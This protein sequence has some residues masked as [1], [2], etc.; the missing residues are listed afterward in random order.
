M[1]PDAVVAVPAVDAVAPVTPAE[2]VAP[3]PEPQPA[4][5]PTVVP[6][7][8]GPPV[9]PQ[10]PV[11]HAVDQ[12]VPDD[13]EFGPEPL[14][15]EPVRRRDPSVPM[16]A[17]PALPVMAPPKSGP[18][19]PPEAVA[20]VAQ[21]A[22]PPA[23][24]VPAQAMVWIRQPDPD[25][26]VPPM[27][28]QS[29]G[30]VCASDTPAVPPAVAAMIL[31]P[32]TLPPKAPTVAMSPVA[33]V[34]KA[35]PVPAVAEASPPPGSLVFTDDLFGP[36]GVPLPVQSTTE[37]CILCGAPPSGSSGPAAP[38]GSGSGS[39]LD[40]EHQFTRQSIAKAVAAVGALGSEDDL[41]FYVESLRELHEYLPHL[42]AAF[43]DIASDVPRPNISVVCL[44]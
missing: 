35:P 27:V 25:S 17:G 33:A 34:A 2:A 26:G 23:S 44:V 38:G 24:G 30:R 3:Q 39:A 18:V 15:M 40:K 36:P 19:P 16:A 31:G 13:M 4:V 28:G 6:P 32:D 37:F 9:A 7:A 12:P 1:Q 20:P 14:P 42:I 8:E 22:P 10:P 29:F 21:G 41:A 11:P 43:T 5:A